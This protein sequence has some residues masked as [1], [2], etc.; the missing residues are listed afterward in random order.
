MAHENQTKRVRD[1][2]EWRGRSGFGRELDEA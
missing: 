2:V 1:L